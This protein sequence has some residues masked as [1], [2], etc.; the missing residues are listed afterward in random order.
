LHD[1][2][3]RD[4]L[5]TGNMGLGWGSGHPGGPGPMGTVIDHATI[6]GN[7]GDLQYWEAA[8]GGDIYI[9]R[10][11]QLLANGG[12]TITN[13]RIA[14]SQWANQGEGARFQY[15]YVNRQLTNQPLLPWPMENRIEDELGL[16]I[17]HLIDQYSIE[18]VYRGCTCGVLTDTMTTCET[19]P[20]P[21]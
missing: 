2:V 20:A 15:R 1:N 21:E 9:D 13:S 10:R 16:D 3:Y 18:S 11:D 19:C 7:G 6:Y 8:Q 4:I 5:A 14:N 17:T 12:L